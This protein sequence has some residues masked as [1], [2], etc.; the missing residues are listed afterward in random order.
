MAAIRSTDNS[1][2][3]A[4]K[5]S[6]WIHKGTV[7]NVDL[8]NWTV[9]VVGE[10]E[11]EFWANL[12][13][14]CPY[15]HT[16]NGEG[17]FVMPEVGSL[18][19][20]CEPSDEDTPYVIGFIGS[21]ELEHAKQ[22]NLEDK[23]GA[24]DTETEEL[25]GVLKSMG[26]AKSTTST[27]AAEDKTTGASSRAGRPFLNPGDI[28][29]R[30][31]DENFIVLRRGGVVQI[32]STPTCQSVYIPLLNYLKH[33]AENYEVT[34]PGGELEW[35][36]QRKENGP[37]G[38]APVL[39][40]LTLRDKAQNDKADIQIKMGHVS[41][42]DRY[43]L[44]VAPGNIKVEKGEVSGTPKLKMVI[45]KDGD[46]KYEMDGNLEYDIKGNR[47]VKI[48]G[49]DTV[50]VTG[51]RTVK[52]LSLLQDIKTSHIL[53]AVS[54]TEKI[55]GAKTIS[56]ATVSLGNA[57]GSSA[58][59]GELLVAW[60]GSHVHAPLWFNPDPKAAKLDNILSK[61]IKISP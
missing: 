27:G 11:G 37:D 53:K 18:C 40:R 6:A 3:R 26:T 61:T 21:F 30:T 24:A 14:A 25:A 9:D 17:I 60:L 49:T 45:T 51:A 1:P 28:M 54:S 39:Y 8:K 15:L 23:A 41:D 5:D 56:A 22:D 29:L 59:L 52:A 47:S 50:E 57:P 7:A 58:V 48:K 20:V 36:V 55:T 43:E 4:G 10:Y 2:S 31:R 19:L 13:W 16:N 33:F 42:S 38:K 12:Q 46:Q 34:T 32:G 35:T 44:V